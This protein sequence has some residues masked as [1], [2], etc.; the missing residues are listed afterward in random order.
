MK[1]ILKVLAMVGVLSSLSFSAARTQDLDANITFRFVSE[2]P[3]VVHFEF[4]SQNYNR[5]WPGGGEVYVLDDWETREV[6]LNCEFGEE[7]AWGAWV[8]NNPS[9][10]WGSGRNGSQSCESCVYTCGM[11]NPATQI[12]NE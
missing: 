11:D 4:N 8:K 5:T 7:I 10:Y 1:T 3:Y 2:Y 9:I 6:T 12:L